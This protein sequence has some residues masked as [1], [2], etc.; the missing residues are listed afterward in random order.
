MKVTLV[1]G[2]PGS[3]KT[4]YVQQRRN[5][6]D[7]VWDFDV[8]MQAITGLPMHEKP[9]DVIGLV[10]GMRT[11]FFG[12]L[13]SRRPQKHV[14]IIGTCPT[15]RERAEITQRFGADLV[16]LDTD[17]ATCR[18]RLL[19]RGHSAESVRKYFERLEP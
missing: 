10:L 15:R 4:T 13:E 8:I 6:G 17:E 16:V 1:C 14:W 2:A 18:A 9:E 11:G 7:I 19:A 12:A 3:G 5:P